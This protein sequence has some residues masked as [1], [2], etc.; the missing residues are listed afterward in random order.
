MSVQ[1]DAIA[2]TS[3]IGQLHERV[4]DSFRRRDSLPNTDDELPYAQHVNALVA[5]RY[6][7]DIGRR[8][9]CMLFNIVKIK[10]SIGCLEF[11]LLPC[12]GFSHLN[13]FSVT[14]LRLLRRG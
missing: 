14:I 2:E 12:T 10:A 3:M 4:I 13:C 8:L 5:E 11:V 7:A 6:R 1:H 9:I